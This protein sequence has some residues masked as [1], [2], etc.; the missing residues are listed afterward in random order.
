MLDFIDI[1]KR[2]SRCGYG[3]SEFLRKFS[4]DNPTVLTMTGFEPVIGVAGTIP[5]DKIIKIENVPANAQIVRTYTDKG[6]QYNA[7]VLDK[8][9]VWLVLY[10]PNN[11]DIAQTGMKLLASVAEAAHKNKIKIF[12]TGNDI[13][14][15]TGT[16]KKKFCGYS[17]HQWEGW[18]SFELFVSLEVNWDIMRSI[19]D[20]TQEKFTKKGNFGDISNIVGGLKESNPNLNYG[21]SNDIV[22]ALAKRLGLKLNKRALT[23]DEEK[24]FKWLEDRMDV[25]S[26]KY[27]GIYPFKK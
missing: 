14:L 18:T 19:Y 2:H 16:N 4:I 13:Y 24:D 9:F 8:D 5:L 22:S 1:G 6:D 17:L 21:L 25:D 20:F 26:W 3:G 23:D 15:D 27:D 11:Y 7:I 12:S 10:V